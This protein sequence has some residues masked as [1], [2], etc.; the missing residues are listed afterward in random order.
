M[1]KR[2]LQNPWL[3]VV[4]SGTT[5][6]YFLIFAQFGYLHLLMS[7]PQTGN[8]IEIVMGVM[9]TGGILGSIH[10][11]RRFDLEHAG[12]W[13][14]TGLMGSGFAAVLSIMV[15]GMWLHIAVALAV[16][17]SLGV[18]T[19]AIVPTIRALA[20]TGQVGSWVS[21]GVG[22][23]YFLCNIP[24]V[25]NSSAVNHCLLGGLASCIGLTG[26][27]FMPQFQK[28]ILDFAGDPE[29]SPGY[30]FKT[31]GVIIVTVLF[32]L[33]IWLD[34]AAFYLIQE[35]DSLKAS[36]W[37]TNGQLWINASVHFVSAYI[38]GYLLDRGWF[39]ASLPVSLVF[40]IMGYMWLNQG[41]IGSGM[42]GLVYVAGV[43]I[44]STSLVAY[45]ALASQGNGRWSISAR[46]GMVFAIGGWFG[47]AMGVGM[48]RDLQI[49]PTAFLIVLLMGMLGGIMA[50]FRL[51]T[52]RG[53]V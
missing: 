10:A 31:R 19:V 34:S 52:L 30:L 51:K 16:G 18:L 23:A 47:S 1:I 26:T 21:L 15:S 42:A 45:G 50:M 5:F 12:K 38:C 2:D 3:V 44:Y 8:L 9:G 13:I 20:P 29:K 39:M 14:S 41:V 6:F 33:L 22:G 48:A 53:K 36:S 7:I 11:A 46:A 35:S 24:W 49:V 4:L 17:L 25:F 27:L 43:S 32:A 37:G 40:L 28:G